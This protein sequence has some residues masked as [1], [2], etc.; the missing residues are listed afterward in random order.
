MAWKGLGYAAAVAVL[1]LA[2]I[3]RAG[4]NQSGGAPSDSSAPA[5]AYPLY[6]DDTTTPATAPAAPAS[7]PSP[8]ETPVMFL[9]HPTGFGQ[10]LENNKLSITGFVEG[11]YF[12]DT[13]NP[14]SH[15]DQPTL[16]NFPGT[17]SDH[18][19]LDQV[20]VT[21]SKA[22]DSTKSWDWGFTFENGYGT[23]DAFIHSAGMLDNRPPNDPQNQYDIPQANVELLVPLGT[24][25]T[26]EAGKF[27]TIFS[28]EVINPTGDQFYSHSYSFS[29]GVPFTSTGITG[30]YTFP[31]LLN[32]NDLTVTA[33]IS[34]GWN[35]SLRDNNGSIDFL[36]QAKS[37]ITSAL[38]YVF[39][40]EIGPQAIP[41]PRDAPQNHSNYETN[42]ELIL[43][44][45][46]SS[47]LTVVGDF[48][49]SDFPNE[50]ATGSAQWYGACGYGQYK[51]NSYLAF[52]LRGEWYRDQGAFTTGTQA[53]YYEATAGVQIHPLPNDNIFQFLQIRP[54]VRED[55]SD[56]RVYD[57]PHDGGLGNYNEL[58]FAV[59][60]VM[61]F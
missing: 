7:A 5:L 8:P 59:D 21:L 10:W 35:Q 26:I 22:I 46:V 39:N 4:P 3:S 9:L 48:L 30:S 47:E 28:N 53:N 52:N 6:L 34:E 29:F 16:I 20:D 55:V 14:N 24:G 51:F 27:L 42:A 11:G 49:Y 43:T 50:G 54:E 18:V 1:G 13:N 58:T 61:Q 23:D 41:V 32:G 25:L 12:L 15:K 17:Y 19:L 37:N 45:N 38:S 57:F 36:G 44:E 40:F 33:G 60:V 31:K 2:S 56:R